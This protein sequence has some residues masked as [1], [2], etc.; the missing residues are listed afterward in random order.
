MTN[1]DIDLK[2]ITERMDELKNQQ[3]AL[4]FDLKNVEKEIEK[5]ELQLATVLEKQTLTVWIMA[6]IVSVGK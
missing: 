4:K 1:L 3:A 2:E 5:C 6:F